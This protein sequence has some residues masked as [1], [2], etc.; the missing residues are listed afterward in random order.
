MME[1]MG[2][3]TGLLE[4]GGAEWEK[5]DRQEQSKGKGSQ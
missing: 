2:E 5:A 4:A 3:E 1:D